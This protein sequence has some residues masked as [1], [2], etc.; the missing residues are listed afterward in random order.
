M[1]TV[2]LETH[3]HSKA[4]GPE[5]RPAPKLEGCRVYP[6]DLAVNVVNFPRGNVDSARVVFRQQDLERILRHNASSD[7]M[8]SESS[9]SSSACSSIGSTE[10]KTRLEIFGLPR[11]VNS[12]RVVFRAADLE[13]IA[14]ST[15]VWP[16]AQS[17]VAQSPAEVV[18]VFA[19]AAAVPASHGPHIIANA[20]DIF[21]L[22]EMQQALSVLLAW[23]ILTLF[24][25]LF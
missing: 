4:C 3:L 19:T 24:T 25:L 16:A 15:P 10:P 5:A 7:S 20:A 6:S 2:E 22:L 11:N 23:F 21:A 13:H 8:L 1:P 14:L 17:V 18:E 12:A 9:A